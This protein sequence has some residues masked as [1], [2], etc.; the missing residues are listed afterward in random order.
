METMEHRDINAEIEDL[1]AQIRGIAPEVVAGDKAAL[2]KAAKL[3]MDIQGL[4][5]EQQIRTLASQEEQ[6]RA[7]EAAAAQDQAIRKAALKEFVKGAGALIDLEKKITGLV[8]DLGAA[9]NQYVTLTKDLERLSNRAASPSVSLT[10]G[11]LARDLEHFLRARM[12]PFITGLQGTRADA[13][14]LET[15]HAH[16]LEIAKAALAMPLGPRKRREPVEDTE[17]NIHEPANG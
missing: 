2:A 9:A 13:V 14:A 1:E 15:K 8:D 17:L 5:D 11:N 7:N 4:Q 3:R 12:K 16:I 10:K 6:R